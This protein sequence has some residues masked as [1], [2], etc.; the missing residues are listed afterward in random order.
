MSPESALVVRRGSGG[1]AAEGG[2]GPTAASRDAYSKYGS[3][4]EYPPFLRLAS[5]AGWQK[6]VVAHEHLGRG[7]TS[8]TTE[9]TSRRP[10]RPAP[11]ASCLLHRGGMAGSRRQHRGE[12]GEEE[13]R[14]R[15][16][17]IGSLFSPAAS[18]DRSQSRAR[19]GREGTHR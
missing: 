17:F 15:V 3:R 19:V 18:L 5:P 9:L 11:G 8:E 10:W 4:R 14:P 2:A 7:W 12:G 16:S 1:A 6:R 13:Q